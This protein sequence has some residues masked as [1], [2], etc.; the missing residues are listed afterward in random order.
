MRRMQ[1]KYIDSDEFQVLMGDLKGGITT[2]EAIYLASLAA[3]ISDGCIVEVGSFRGK[4][5]VALALGVRDR[6]SEKAP[7]IY[8]I[9]P[10]QP[11]TGFYGGKFGPQDRKAFYETM[12][13]TGAYNE[14]S[15]INLSS[16]I[17]TPSWKTPVGFIFIDGD[18]HYA[19]VRRDFECWESQ[20]L[21]GG[22]IA[23]DDAINQS[24]GPSQLIK[25]IL[26]TNNYEFFSQKGKIV[27]LKKKPVNNIKPIN[28]QFANNK[29]RILVLCDL[30]IR[31]GG[32]LRFDRIYNVIKNWDYELYFLPLSNEKI[33]EKIM[34]NS[35]IIK[36]EEALCIEWDVTM[37]PGAG[38]PEHT[39]KKFADFQDKKFG[40]RIQHIL[41]DTTKKE[42]FL[43]VNKVF[44]PHIVLFNNDSWDVGTYT[45][46][47]ANQFYFLIGGVDTIKFYP[48]ALKPVKNLYQNIYIGG[49]AR[50][51]PEVLI[52]TLEYLPANY[53]IK[54][55]G[56]PK[57]NLVKRYKTLI[58]AGRLELI[59]VLNE[60]DLVEYYKSIDVIVSTEKF[61]GWSNMG[62]EAMA[63]GIPLICTHHGTSSYA[64]DA[65]TALIID[66][67][68]S[69]KIS[70]KITSLLHDPE[71]CYKLSNNGRAAIIEFDWSKYSENLCTYF[72]HDYV[73]HYIR[74][75][76]LELYGKWPVSTRL[77]GL[78]DVLIRAR[79]KTVLDFGSAEGV[80]AYEFLKNYAKFLVGFEIDNDRV[81]KSR[82][83]C[84]KFSNFNFYCEDLNNWIK[85]KKNYEHT[86]SDGVD[87]VLYLGIHHHLHKVAREQVL[88]D[89]LKITNNLFVIRT[90]KAFFDSDNIE[91][92]II[93]KGYILMNEYEGA[94]DSSGVLKI[95][96]KI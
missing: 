15:L 63:C 67:L 57:G 34:L 88:L 19:G 31:S 2:E 30:V 87:I 12:I 33:N 49:D 60:S 22:L 29:K 40:L 95:F 86:Y 3:N 58:E 5:G 43:S 7:L 77:H 10:H 70:D 8:C 92:L 78:S 76:Q 68:D 18:H 9:D 61:A 11:F 51:N 48:T 39:I 47:H 80:V 13:S 90:P 1:K 71:L 62:A 82:G 23:F 72:K 38:F 24:C 25:E 20:I 27:T 14:V 55:F 28:S 96:E 66:E 74:Q 45:E 44:K 36:E 53:F 35:K 50:K 59:G 89:L 91:D 32:L 83:I 75:P 56:Q 85:I 46:F 54:L 69:K 81:E 41:N 37:V 79:N 26:V 52:D 65:Q 6:E 4:S 94:I 84:S 93:S 21:P 16:E 42:A 17:I 73:Q 64:F